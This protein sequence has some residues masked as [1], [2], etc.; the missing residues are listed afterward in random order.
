MYDFHPYPSKSSFI[1]T[2]EIHGVKVFG[3]CMICVGQFWQGYKP[4]PPLPQKCSALLI[5][6]HCVSLS[7][8]C[9]II[10]GSPEL[11]G[12]E[13]VFEPF[14]ANAQT[15]IHTHSSQ[16]AVPNADANVLT[17]SNALP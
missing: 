8:F 7:L 2:L 14:V 3:L 11:Y 17:R 1:V 6:H 10:Q 5:S 12:R 15:G 4:F 13:T 9:H 16:Q